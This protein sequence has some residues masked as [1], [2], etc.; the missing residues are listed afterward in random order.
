MVH[1]YWLHHGGIVTYSIQTT[2]PKLFF[3]G[4]KKSQC[5][6]C[7]PKMMNYIILLKN[8]QFVNT[9]NNFTLLNFLKFKTK[10]F[11]TSELHYISM[12][13]VMMVNTI[14]PK[15]DNDSP[16]TNKDPNKTYFFDE[17]IP[18]MF[19]SISIQNANW[20]NQQDQRL[21]TERKHLTNTCCSHNKEN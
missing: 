2:D 21:Y 9:P 20:E 4:A 7:L 5:L 10:I 6:I 11:W 15:I 16:M 17:N 13:Y 14:P 18:V 19:S 1:L 12:F 3:V 8:I